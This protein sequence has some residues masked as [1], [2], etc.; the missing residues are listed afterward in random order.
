MGDDAV[1]EFSKEADEICLKMVELL[2]LT[3]REKMKA[4]TNRGLL[5]R[6]NQYLNSNPRVK[7][8]DKKP[9]GIPKGMKIYDR[10]V[11]VTQGKMSFAKI[12]PSTNEVVELFESI[13]DIASSLGVDNGTVRYRLRNS[14][15]MEGYSYRQV[16][17]I[18]LCK[19]CNEWV[20]EKDRYVT[21]KDGKRVVISPMCKTCHVGIRKT[22]KE[23]KNDS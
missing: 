12:D 14:D 18:K 21:Y 10:G 17:T 9:K 6:V 8:K 3:H 23:V 5:L 1:N 4:L 19:G 22:K 2:K 7:P 15:I 11:F 20:T 16:E 13:A